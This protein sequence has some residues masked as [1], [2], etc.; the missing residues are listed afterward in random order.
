MHE[1][2]ERQKRAIRE[3]QEEQKIV[4]NPNNGEILCDT[5]FEEQLLQDAEN[6]ENFLHPDVLEKLRGNKYSVLKISL[7]GK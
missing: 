4:I 5:I 7:N 1:K 2:Q 3:Y 6:Y